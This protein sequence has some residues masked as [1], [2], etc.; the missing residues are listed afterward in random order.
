MLNEKKNTKNWG[1]LVVRKGGEGGLYPFREGGDCVG[2]SHPQLISGSSASWS[3][4]G[5][6]GEISWPIHNFIS[7]GSSDRVKLKITR[8]WRPD[9]RHYLRTFVNYRR[10]AKRFWF[11]QITDFLFDCFYLYIQFV[12]DLPVR[13]AL[14]S[15][16]A[17]QRRKFLIIILC[18]RLQ[19]KNGSNFAPKP[20]NFL[21]RESLYSIRRYK[22]RRNIS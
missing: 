3:A 4:S 9:W 12:I 21:Y 16:S 22:N 13:F 2:C 7:I 11:L 10:D 1:H 6:L 18:D 8:K 15:D 20:Q 17:D 5:H 19:P 14:Y